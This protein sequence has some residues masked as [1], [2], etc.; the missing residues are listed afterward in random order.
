M[1]TCAYSTQWDEAGQGKQNRYQMFLPSGEVSRSGAEGK[2]NSGTPSHSARAGNLLDSR[3]SIRGS[4]VIVMADQT[5]SAPSAIALIG[6]GEMGGVFARAFLRSGYSVYPVLRN[7][8]MARSAEA[9]PDPGLAL[10]TVGEA[11]LPGVMAGLPQAWKARTGLIQN[12]LLPRDWLAAGIADPTV[13]VVWFEKKPGSDVKEIIPSPVGG[14]AASVVV[15][16]LE[17]LDIGSFVV[18]DADHL[19]WELVRKNLYILT[20]N[21]AGLA[22]GG[23][24]MDV[25]DEHCDLASRVAD[26]VLDIQEWLVGHALDRS[27]LVDAMVEAFKADPEH[28][29]TGRSAPSRLAR[30]ISHADSAGL[31]VPA[32]RSIQHDTS[33]A[34]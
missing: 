15:E 19:E 18:T 33:A 32:L 31:D 25:W 34:I 22:D 1:P 16:A 11:D 4:S 26:E 3:F 7:T 10:V 13:A 2:E 8:A 27:S 29:A 17:N 9:V 5:N 23:T 28:G 6:V 30:A 21:I 14:P 12:E 24:V 20:A